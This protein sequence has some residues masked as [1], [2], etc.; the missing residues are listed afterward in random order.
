MRRLGFIGLG[1]MGG[2]MARHLLQSGHE[3]VVCDTL[4]AAVAAVADGAKA[5]G[6]KQVVCVSSP[7]EVVEQ[8]AGERSAVFTMLPNAEI[9]RDCYSKGRT[10]I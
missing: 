9:V 10:T 6:D 1:Q 5:R 3:L 8:L 7:S 2:R 4:P